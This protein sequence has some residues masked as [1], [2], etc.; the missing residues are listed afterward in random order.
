MRPECSG[1]GTQGNIRDRMMDVRQHFLASGHRALAPDIQAILIEREHAA[2]PLS[3][4]QKEFIVP[5]AGC[6][7]QPADKL[8]YLQPADNYGLR[9]KAGVDISL[10]E[11]AKQRASRRAGLADVHA[12]CD[13]RNRFVRLEL[14]AL[15]KKWREPV[16]VS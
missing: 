16:L 13:R 15:D 6:T 3:P 10:A 8:L 12:G 9:R 11:Q 14:F 5:G 7:L 1:P 2:R 4:R